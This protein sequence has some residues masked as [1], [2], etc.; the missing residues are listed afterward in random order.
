M[1]SKKKTPSERSLGKKRFKTSEK[2][3][4]SAVYVAQPGNNYFLI[5]QRQFSDHFVCLGAM[6]RGALLGNLNFNRLNTQYPQLSLKIPPEGSTGLAQ[7][8]LSQK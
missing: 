3:G 6:Y 7:T 5:I 4:K 1:S 8:K 2:T